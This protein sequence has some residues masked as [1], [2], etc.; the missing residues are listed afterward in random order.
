MKPS[1]PLFSKP[2][3]SSAL[4]PLITKPTRGE[5]RARLEVLAKKKRSVKR[6]TPASP[7]GCS[8]AQGKTLKVGVSSSL[9]S[10]VGAGDPSRR[11][12]EPPLEVLPISVWSP[13]SQGPEPP[14]PMSD[15]VGRGRFGA[16]G[17]EDSLLS[18]VELAVELFPPF[19]KIP[20]SKRWAPCLLRTLWLFYSREPLIYVL[21]PLSIHFLIVSDC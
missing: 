17:N 21:A 8:P 10:I 9:S 5:L 20:T 1:L 14:P 6:K 19:F 18:H 2:S 12:V 7:E 11:A 3:S 13:M 4:E 15:D 16:V